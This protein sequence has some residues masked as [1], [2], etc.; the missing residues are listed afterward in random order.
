MYIKILIAAVLLLVST[1]NKKNA[2]LEN[3][4]KS[5]FYYIQNTSQELKNTEDFFEK[6]EEENIKEETQEI[7]DTSD[8]FE[9]DNKKTEKETV[10]N[11]KSNRIIESVSGKAIEKSDTLISVDDSLEIFLT[12][13]PTKKVLPTITPKPTEDPLP[14]TV[15]EKPKPTILI[16][17]PPKKPCDPFVPPPGFLLNKPQIEAV[18]CKY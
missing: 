7:I 6:S 2:N 5:A 12:P 17:Q 9:K 15:L 8:F 3:I 16:T 11:I 4:T 18:D 10:H 1:A 14:T 13:V